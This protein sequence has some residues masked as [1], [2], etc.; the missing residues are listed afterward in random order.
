M[1]A[2][3]GVR[4]DTRKPI[5]H[6]V[7]HLVDEATQEV[8]GRD[9][10][11]TSTNDGR[12]SPNSLHYEDYAQDLRVNDRPANLHERYAATVRQK[13]KGWNDDLAPYWDIIYEPDRHP[14][15]AIDTSHVHMEF[16]IRRWSDDNGGRNYPM[17][18][19]DLPEPDIGMVGPGPAE[20][21]EAA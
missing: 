4:L 5:L 3:P 6:A 17:A 19:P 8:F 10:I 12:H 15:A 18:L 11:V 7:D 13:V 9:S 14:D 21:L 2:K 20:Y 1:D 16:D